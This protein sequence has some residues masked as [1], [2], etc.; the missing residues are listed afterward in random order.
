MVCP[1]CG[2]EYREGFTH[3]SDCDVD[4]IVAPPSPPDERNKIEIVQVYEAGNPALLAV[5]ESLLDDAGIE[6]SKSLEALQG[7][8][9]GGR[10]ASGVNYLVGPVK[11]FVRAED[12][13]EARALLDQ[14]QEE[15]PPELPAE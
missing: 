7:I 14:L 11:F 12:E 1:E 3:C 2:A 10:F 8:I 5:A 13:E 9:G 15:P 6:Y 4:L